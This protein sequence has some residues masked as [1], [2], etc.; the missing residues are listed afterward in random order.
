[1]KITT[2]LLICFV[3]TNAGIC[4]AD[5]L[6][7]KQGVKVQGVLVNANSEEI[8]F[9]RT[10]GQETTYPVKAVAGVDFAPLPPPPA[11]KPPPSAA[12]PTIPAGTQ[13][14]VRTIDSIKGSAG[15]VGARYQATVDDPVSLGSQIVIPAGSNCTLEIVKVQSGSDMA[16]RL[17]DVY[18]N[19]KIYTTY[20]QYATIDATG[21]SKTKKAVRRGIGLG[22]LGA[23]IGAIA[24]GGQGAAI[25]A[26]VGGGVGAI[27]AAAA[28][29]KQL[30][31]PSETRLIF[32]LSAPLPLN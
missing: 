2:T 16:L 20:T 15:N 12:V 27:S 21:T 29:G 3:L 13:I 14:T 26:V 30:N 23:G 24:G 22:A 7:L 17:R 9:M 25:G 19:G 28:Q 11:P 18:V 6:R 32:P 1:M 5:I 31:V 4:H 8:V 10:D